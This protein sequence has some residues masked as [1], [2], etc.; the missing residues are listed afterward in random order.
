MEKHIALLKQNAQQVQKNAYAPYSN[1]K[2]GAA[3][4]AEDNN[5]YKGCNVE[6]AS[7]P[8]GQ[9]AEA[10]AIGNMV[11]QGCS[12]IST[13]FILSPNNEF[14]PPCGGCRQK[15][16]EFA[17]PST[18]II[19]GTQDGKTKTVSIGELLPLAFDLN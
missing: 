9:C 7:Y 8:L 16:K 3:L 18:Q 17:T 10:S 5:I 13:I 14:C 4:V 11:G 15:I 1:F 19:L 6:N 2:V 12:K